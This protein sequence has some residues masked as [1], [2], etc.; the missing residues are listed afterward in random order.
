MKPFRWSSGS[1]E[2]MR[3][4]VRD[5]QARQLVED[6]FLELLN[7]IVDLVSLIGESGHE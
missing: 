2:G 6:L 5:K 7:L 4:L 3:F 1:S